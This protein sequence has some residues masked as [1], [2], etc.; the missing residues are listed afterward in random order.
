MR[1]S[2]QHRSSS[3]SDRIRQESIGTASHR[4]SDIS[5]KDG[6]SSRQHQRNSYVSNTSNT[7]AASKSS[8][9][10][11]PS[12][13]HPP[14]IALFGAGSKTATHFLRQAL[15]AGY[16]VRAM[17]IQQS[18]SKK[19]IENREALNLPHRDSRVHSLA[20]EL[21]DEFSA[22]EALA[23]LR[24]IRADSIFD[25]EAIRRTLQ[26]AQYVV[27]MMQD[28]AP[29]ASYSTSYDNT[30]IGYNKHVTTN[31]RSQLI[32]LDPSSKTICADH[33]KPMTSFLQIL[34][35]IMKE[36]ISIQVFLYQVGGTTCLYLSVLDP[37]YDTLARS[38]RFANVFFFRQTLLQL[39]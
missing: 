5:Y 24:W 32:P 9:Y 1:R 39:T 3:G 2:E 38:S 11:K 4:T 26:D 21:R 17:I 15:D 28:G 36:E 8:A 37:H 20:Q 12:D 27:C 19:M 6:Q 16:H 35:P 34:Y 25:V 7:T 18:S 13:H 30:S 14:T 23:Y 33:S 29:I 31:K 22:Q 10:V